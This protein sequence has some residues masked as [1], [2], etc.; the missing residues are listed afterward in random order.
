MAGCSARVAPAAAGVWG[1]LPEQGAR[2]T[3]VGWS[4]GAWRCVRKWH[5]SA[6]DVVRLVMQVLA[7]QQGSVLVLC[8]GPA[9]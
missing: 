9:C 7:A 6:A 1:L 5:C 3:G 8:V 2:L 4:G